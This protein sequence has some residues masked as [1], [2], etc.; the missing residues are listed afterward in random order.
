MFNNQGVWNP[1]ALVVALCVMLSIALMSHYIKGKLST[2]PFLISIIGGFALAAGLTGIGY[3]T[4][5]D[6]MKLVDF[7][8]FSNMQWVP[9]F[10][11]E[12]AFDGMEANGFVWSQIPEI[13][14]I[15]APISIVA[16]CEHIGDHMNLSSVVERDL[17]IDPGLQRTA[18]G[19]GVATAVGGLIGGMGNT[20][21]GENVSVVGVTK[22][23]SVWPIFGAAVLAILLGWFAPLMTWVQSIPYC[24]MGGAALVLY[25]FIAVSGLR[26]LAKVD[27]TQSRNIIIASVVLIA[28]VGGLFIQ[29][30]DFQFTGVALAMVLGVILNLIL[31]EKKAQN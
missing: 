18:L 24:V 3:A 26:N 1:W 8:I 23:A 7:S 10:A 29:F 22:V 21:Y 19:D 17:L 25:G 6:S 16:F 9:H 14:L 28:G 12:Y 20:T 30:G 15:A 11:L 4:G 27:L 13:I 5:L 31:R 2:L